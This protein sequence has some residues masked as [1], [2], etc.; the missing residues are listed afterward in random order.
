MSLA[1]PSTIEKSLMSADTF[2]VMRRGINVKAN[3][4]VI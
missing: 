4:L 2:A 3:K 1:I